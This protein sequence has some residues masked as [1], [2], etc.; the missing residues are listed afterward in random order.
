MIAA[1][2]HIARIVCGIVF[3]LAGIIAFWGGSIFFRRFN[4]SRIKS[5]VEN[6]RKPWSLGK[7]TD[8]FMGCWL[9]IVAFIAIFLGLVILSTVLFL[10]W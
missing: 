1:L 5:A 8:F 9:W 2:L 7:T 10:G 4:D 6:T 3:P